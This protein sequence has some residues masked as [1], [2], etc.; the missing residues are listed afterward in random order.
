MT[1]VTDAGGVDPGID[2]NKAVGAARCPSDGDFPYSAAA[3][4]PFSH[5]SFVPNAYLLRLPE[6][7]NAIRILRELF[8]KEGELGRGGVRER[9]IREMG[10]SHDKAELQTPKTPRPRSQTP[11]S[12]FQTPDS[13]T[14][15]SQLQLPN[16]PTPRLFF[17]QIDEN[18]RNSS[19]QLSQR[20]FE[21]EY[22]HEKRNTTT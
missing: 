1:T 15:N 11:N 20:H 12:P 21:M 4:R 8:E 14:P 2:C 5:R 9:E 16:P 22:T 10:A 19:I 18:K 17:F 7:Q 13:P 3:S 6:T